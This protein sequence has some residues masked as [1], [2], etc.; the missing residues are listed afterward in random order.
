MPKRGFVRSRE[1]KTKS[2]GPERA[3]QIGFTDADGLHE[4][5]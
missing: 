4:S 1:E 2:D 3:A 5:E